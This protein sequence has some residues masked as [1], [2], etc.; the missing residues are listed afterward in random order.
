[1]ITHSLTL[2]EIRAAGHRF[3][4]RAPFWPVD[5]PIEYAFNTIEM[6]LSYRMYEIRTVNDMDAHLRAIIR[7]FPA[8]VNYFTNVGYNNYRTYKIINHYTCCNC[9]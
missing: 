2:T 4:F 9:Q 5:G 8:F 3:V 6:A 7:G 1:M